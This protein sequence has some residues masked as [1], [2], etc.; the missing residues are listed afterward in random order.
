MK[1]T[2]C[3]LKQVFSSLPFSHVLFYKN[4]ASGGYYQFL[5]KKKNIANLLRVGEDKCLTSVSLSP[6]IIASSPRLVYK[7][8]TTILCENAPKA[9]MIHSALVSA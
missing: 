3:E 2:E 4:N 5:E 8:E 6:W 9:D 7:V 1:G